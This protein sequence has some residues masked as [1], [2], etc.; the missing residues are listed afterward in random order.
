MGAFTTTP[1]DRMR[2][3][4]VTICM[5]RRKTP[6]EARMGPRRTLQLLLVLTALATLVLALSGVV[7]PA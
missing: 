4:R 6:R 3:T 2:G 1:R 7:G 5:V